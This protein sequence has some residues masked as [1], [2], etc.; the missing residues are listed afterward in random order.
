MLAARLAPLQRRDGG[1]GKGAGTQGLRL[2]D[3]MTAK[4]ISQQKVNADHFSLSPLS[5]CFEMKEFLVGVHANACD[6]DWITG[7]GTVTLHTG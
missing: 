7:G 1:G 5:A 4:L 2:V 6:Q 3:W